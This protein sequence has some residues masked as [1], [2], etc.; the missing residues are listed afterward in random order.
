MSLRKTAIILLLTIATLS[1]FGM[2]IAAAQASA[3]IFEYGEYRTRREG[4]KPADRTASGTTTMI[5][6]YVLVKRTE[7]IN[8]QP[9][10]SFGV[11]FRLAQ[12]LAAGDVLVFRITHPPLTNPKTGRTM[13]ASEFDSE[14]GLGAGEHYVG[15]T[16]DEG[17]EMAEGPWMIQVVQNGKVIAERPFK[18]VVLLN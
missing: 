17:W 9:G 14:P 4:E 6:T 5:S 16:F 12:P 11:Q 7:V 3:D 1:T 8:A 15:F 2:E 18:I 13:T 10:V